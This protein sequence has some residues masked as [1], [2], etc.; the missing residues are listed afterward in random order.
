MTKKLIVTGVSNGIGAHLASRALEHGFDVVGLSRNAPEKNGVDWRYCDVSDPDS[1]KEAV[2]DLKR[3][4]DLFGLINVAGIASM[5][6]TIATPP[7]T[8]HKIIAV[9]LMGTIY[10]C[11]LIGKWLARRKTGRIINF[12]TLAVPLAIKGESVYAASK[13]GVETFTRSFA[14]EMGDFGVTVN[15]I[16]PGPMDTKLIAKVPKKNIDGII[17]QQLICRMGTPED[18]WNITS[19]LLDDASGMVTGDVFHIGGA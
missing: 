8:V 15:V 7:S 18:A 1:I 9:N 3:D 19:F 5:N 16:S 6:L 13:A 10:C 12:S 17:N 11:S 4:E 2:S 14:R